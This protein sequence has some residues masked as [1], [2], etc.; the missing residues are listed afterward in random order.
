MARCDIPPIELM[1]KTGPP[2][3]DAQTRDGR[4]VRPKVLDG[5]WTDWGQRPVPLT[6]PLWLVVLIGIGL[7]LIVFAAYRV[8]TG[9]GVSRAESQAEVT[10]QQE[11]E[12]VRQS[13]V[14]QSDPRIE[15]LNYLRLPAIGDAEAARDLQV[16]FQQN[17]VETYG[18]SG[19]SRAF[20]IW[21]IEPGGLTRE[22]Y[23]QDGQLR[24]RIRNRVLT[25]AR[26]WQK[27]SGISSNTMPFDT[28][29][30]IKYDKAP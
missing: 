5:P 16:Y 30:W 11:I 15:G 6:L 4:R 26:Q 28:T 1:R 29:L 21:V 9:V 13:L 3:P 2:G 12:V 14:T 18:V 10:R 19:D 8:G 27:V 22:Q 25:L 17:G 24:D 23:R 7:L 20:V